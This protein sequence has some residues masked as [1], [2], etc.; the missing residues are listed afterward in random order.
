MKK[1][2]YAKEIAVIFNVC[3]GSVNQW[4]RKGLLPCKKD[5]KG[6]RTYPMDV[7]QYLAEKQKY[8]R[9]CHVE[10]NDDNRY[11]GNVGF[12]CKKCK[13]EF[14]KNNSAIRRR[15][16][17]DEFNKAV[18]R[19]KQKLK[20][21]VF[22]H[23]CNGPIQCKCGFNDIRALSIDHINGDG[24]KQ[25]KELGGAGDRTYRWIKRNNFP[26]GFQILC[27]NCQFIKRY[28]NKENN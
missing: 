17:P 1:Y 14:E 28:E 16:N 15:N 10:L 5:E 13:K 11:A 26:T 20:E 25:K 21:T 2:L 7:V 27:M 8:C 19:A 4:Y 23:Y 22:A 3:T 12:I 18:A 9:V 24:A 6:I